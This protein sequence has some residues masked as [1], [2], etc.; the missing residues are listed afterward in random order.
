MYHS[1][2][3]CVAPMMDCTDRHE[4]YFLRLISKHLR[5]YTEMITTGALLFG[6]QERFLGFDAFEHPIGAQ[7]GGCDPGALATCARMAEQRGYEEVNLNVGC[8]SPRVQA[9]RFGVCLMT[10]PQLVGACVERMQAAVDIPVTVKTRIGV[11]DHD[12][13]DELAS[14][15]ETVA[16]AGCK[17][18]IVHAR[19]AWLKGL[20]P[21][22]NREVPPLRYDVVRALKADFPRYHIILNGGITDLAQATE[23]LHVFDGVM[24]GREAYRNPYMLGPVDQMIFGET[25]PVCERHELVSRYLPYV[26]AQLD[27]GVYLSHMTRHLLGL[28]QGVPGAKA[29]RRCLSTHARKPGAGVEVIEQALD[30]VTTFAPQRPQSGCET[31]QH[32]GSPMQYAS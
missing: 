26:R 28:Y 4:R 24:L 1:H 19:K 31:H 14:F 29:W 13:Y 15:V 20:S 16:S 10:E 23:H 9:G 22:E 7:L 11:D 25:T 18:F 30:C 2:R 12:S 8:P 6:D 21:K 27:Q 5:L 3:F 17:T 32:P